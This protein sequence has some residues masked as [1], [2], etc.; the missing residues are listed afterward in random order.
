MASMKALVR[1]PGPRLPE[2][3]V[4]H[5]HRVPVDLARAHR[6]W[7]DYVE[8]LQWAGWETIEVPEAGD[9]PDAVFIEDTM[10][11]Y[12]NVAVIARP[13]A[14]SRRPEI[15]DAEKTVESL[16]YSI[17]RI[18]PP[19][20]LDGGDVLKVGDTVYV[21]RGGRTNA[22]G[23]SQLRAILEPIGATVVA[24][25]LTKVLH[26]KSAV[27]ALPDGT[28]VGWP[29]AVDDPRLFPRFLATPEESGAHVVLLGNDRLL[30]SA[31][32]PQ[33][34]ALYASLGYEPVIVDIGEFIKL[35]G[36]VTCLSV[37][38]RGLHHK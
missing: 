38:L 18:R 33:S 8:I 10:V 12:K 36:C 23:I 27:T 32:C 3:L 35:E 26:L 30:M 16:G 24:V 4:T 6:Q 22:E 19:G 13:G 37:R 28:V 9:C 14:E 5:V 31:D 17:N 15:I 11:V 21:A 7:Q 2:G 29:P 34:A 20:T 25:P 1:R